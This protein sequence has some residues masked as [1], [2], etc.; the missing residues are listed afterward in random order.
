MK[1]ICLALCLFGSLSPCLATDTSETAVYA[2]K[3]TLCLY[4]MP[5][6]RHSQDILTYLNNIHK[7]LPMKNLQT[8]PEA[9]ADLKKMGGKMQVPCLSINGTPIY[10]SGDIL[11]WLMHHI[12][13]LDNAP[14]Q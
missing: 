5:W 14:T 2:E 8:D 4:Y 12:D 1:N 11:S 13:L 9:K 10:E 7:T 6:C 3:P